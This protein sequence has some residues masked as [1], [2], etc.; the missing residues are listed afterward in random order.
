MT[1]KETYTKTFIEALSIEK[2]KLINLSMS[3]KNKKNLKQK[4]I[5][6]F[7][8][9]PAKGISTQ[10]KKKNLLKI[11][12]ET[13]VSIAI[14]NA[15]KSKYLDDI[16]LSSE[17]Q[18]ILNIAKKLGINSVKRPKK[19]STGHIESKYL[20]FDFLKKN[21]EIKSNDYI[22]YLQ[23][24]S[25]LRSSKHIDDA[26]KIILKSKRNSLT[27]V[28]P[29]DSKI[30]KSLIIK[31]DK[32]KTLFKNDNVSQSRQK[33][34]KVYLPNGSI[35]I[36]KVLNFLKNKNFLVNNSIQY[37]MS[38]NESLDIDSLDD[39]KEFQKKFN[40]KSMA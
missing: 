31:K 20:V 16:F 29:F 40:P 25:P 4:K 5:R 23:P 21:K 39:F 10:I 26:I 11:K 8:L 7:G 13:L 9:I 27:S 38:K 12:G 34:P 33:L 15:K 32:I 1:N 6:F 14:K 30:F 2:N 22:V 36:F 18:K 28:M 19:F 24:T 17:N 35:Y 3:K 37:L